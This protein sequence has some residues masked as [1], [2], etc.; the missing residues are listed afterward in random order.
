[1]RDQRGTDTFV[2]HNY[3]ERFRKLKGLGHG[4]AIYMSLKSRKLQF[5]VFSNHLS[6]QRGNEETSQK[7]E[8]HYFKLHLA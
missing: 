5:L 3:V 2:A 4:S 7:R 6:L 1:M 8:M